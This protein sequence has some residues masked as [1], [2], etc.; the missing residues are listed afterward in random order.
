[1]KGSEK[2]IEMIAMLCAT[3]VITMVKKQ[4]IPVFGQLTLTGEKALNWMK[5]GDEICVRTIW[6]CSVNALSDWNVPEWAKDKGICA[7]IF[8]LN[9]FE[10]PMFITQK[11]VLK[12]LEAQ[13]VVWE[14]AG[15][16]CKIIG[17]KLQGQ[18]MQMHFPEDGPS[19]KFSRP[20]GCPTYAPY[21]VTILD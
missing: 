7:L 13:C 2:M 16:E 5:N 21:E 9:V 19:M 1:M 20:E 11:S 17:T 4:K 8:P 3:I 14:E 6:F 15:A 12:V 10:N 18:K